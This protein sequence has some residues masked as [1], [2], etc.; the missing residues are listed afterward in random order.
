[1]WTKGEF[2]PNGL[3]SRLMCRK[4]GVRLSSDRDGHDRADAIHLHILALLL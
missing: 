3:I 2:T 4:K 1:M